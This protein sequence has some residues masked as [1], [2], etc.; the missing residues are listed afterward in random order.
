L[1]PSN[2]NREESVKVKYRSLCELL[3]NLPLEEGRCEH[4]Q[5]DFRPIIACTNSMAL[6]FAIEEANKDGRLP[7]AED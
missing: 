5:R 6:L 2:E 3:E 7:K 4:R 1:K